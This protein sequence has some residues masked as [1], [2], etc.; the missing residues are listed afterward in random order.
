M[1]PRTRWTTTI[2]ALALLGG[3]LPFS[4]VPAFA[5][6]CTPGT[7]GGQGYGS[8]TV[9]F[10]GTAISVTITHPRAPLFS[11]DDP[12]E[13]VFQVETVYKGRLT[14]RATV[15]TVASSAS[16]GYEFQPG[17]RYT[18]FAQSRDGALSTHM[19]SGNVKGGIDPARNNLL[20]G[21][22]PEPS[23]PQRLPVTG[24]GTSAEPSAAQHGPVILWIPLA[25]GLVSALGG[26]LLWRRESP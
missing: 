24:R 13:A 6:S 3:L 19:C 18:V 14:E 8:D 4:T 20:A 10:T 25:V 23:A 11:S 12:L 22:P 26:F 2:A 21:V 1:A 5:C 17:Q 9:V 7:P 15:R 16:C